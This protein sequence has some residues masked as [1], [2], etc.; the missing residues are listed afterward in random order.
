MA[1]EPNLEAADI[2]TKKKPRTGKA[3]PIA[4]KTFKSDARRADTVK[5]AGPA[6]PRDK[7]IDRL[8]KDN[9]E[10]GVQEA[11]LYADLALE[12]F[13]AQDNIDRIGPI[14]LHPRTSQI[15]DN[16]YI[17][18]RDSARNAILAKFPDMG[19]GWLW[20]Q[21]TAPLRKK[22]LQSI[23]DDRAAADK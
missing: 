9:I 21:G 12:Y 15:I 23:A 5:R 14:A 18:I 20:A 3:Q 6:M 8:L 1:D 16:P 11:F 4:A 2:S 7:I 22:W 17:K 13:E 10:L 19:A